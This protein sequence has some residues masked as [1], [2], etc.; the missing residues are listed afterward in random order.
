M[1]PFSS[2]FI[3]LSFASSTVI[4]IHSYLEDMMNRLVG[5]IAFHVKPKTSY[6]TF[7]RKSG[8]SNFACAKA[9]IVEISNLNL[10]EV[11]DQYQELENIDQLRNQLVHAGG[12]L[13]ISEE[14]DLNRYVTESK[15]LS[16]APES[17]VKIQSGFIEFYIDV[18][19]KFFDGLDN[20]VAEFTLR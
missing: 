11:E 1:N 20:E 4:S 10:L 18:L 8:G 19:V 13:P 15:L 16:G 14:H 6:K 17:K 12:H 5:L 2:I 9:Y 3:F 7:K